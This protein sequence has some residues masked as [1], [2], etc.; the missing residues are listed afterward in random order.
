MTEKKSDDLI[1]KFA[2]NLIEGINDFNRLNEQAVKAVK[3]ILPKPEIF[4]KE[5]SSLQVKAL[6]YFRNLSKGTPKSQLAAEGESGIR[7][8]TL[9]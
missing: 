9:A 3:R 6:D 7:R 2:S 1:K 4:L 5:F 8:L